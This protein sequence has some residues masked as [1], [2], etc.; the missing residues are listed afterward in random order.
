MPDP[1][2]LMLHLR[3]V[4]RPVDDAALV[5]PFV[6]APE[7]DGVAYGQRFNARGD[8]DVVCDEEG[9]PGFE[10]HDESLVPV[11]LAVVAEDPGDSS[12]AGDLDSALPVLEGR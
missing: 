12:R 2:C 10:R 6:L 11:A 7:D 8:I 4:M 3:V 1:T 5:V 9:L